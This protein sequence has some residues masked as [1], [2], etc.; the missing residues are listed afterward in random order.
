MPSLFLSLEAEKEFD[1]VHWGLLKAVLLKFGVHSWFHSAI[2]SLY[3]N[4]R[5]KVLTSG[6][7]STPLT[8]TNKTRQGCPLSP[9]I[10][11]LLMEPL[12]AKIRSHTQILG[13][14]FH[15]SE[16]KLSLFVDDVILMLSNPL[17][18]L[19]IIQRPSKTLALYPT[20]S[21]TPQSP[22]F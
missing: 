9:L 14:P 20:T 8:I 7:L 5:A 19:P 18:S 21:S 2:L 1:H 13:I 15:N 17:Q 4:P 16:H 12:A 3:S 22:Y 10:L 6:T 11:A